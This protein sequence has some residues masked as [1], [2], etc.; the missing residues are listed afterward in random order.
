[1]R[2]FSTLTKLLLGQP[3]GF[4]QCIRRPYDMGLPGDREE[5]L[6]RLPEGALPTVKTLVVWPG[7]I[8]VAAVLKAC[9]NIETL[10]L[11][12]GE[13]KRLVIPGGK[14]SPEAA[15][16]QAF[17]TGLVRVNERHGIMAALDAASKAASLK[18]FEMFKFGRQYIHGAMW[19]DATIG[20]S[21][22]WAP[23]DVQVIAEYLPNISRLCLYGNID[24]E[25]RATVCRLPLS[26]S[27]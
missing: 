24:D 14:L 10:K 21:P 15:A 25:T 4:S 13:A 22:G 1:M 9:P 16:T 12:V 19:G 3:S 2:S 8:D 11:N 27:M 7:A 20:I 18:A 23:S 26:T 6:L 17:K 5:S